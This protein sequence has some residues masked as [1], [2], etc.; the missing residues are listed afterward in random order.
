MVSFMLP[1]YGR[2]LSEQR[3]VVKKIWRV[4][5]PPSP[6]DDGIQATNLMKR[7]DGTVA[8]YYARK[9]PLP[10]VKDRPNPHTIASMDRWT[11]H[12]PGQHPFWADYMLSG[13]SLADFPGVT[14]AHKQ[15]PEAT[16]EILVAA[17]DPD[18]P[19][20]NLDQGGVQILEPLTHV[21]Q[22]TTTDER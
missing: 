13:S 2:I 15:F 20:E 7:I 1:L 11:L 21:V 3:S 5:F 8:G 4:A 19:K 14:P 10:P 9:W 17:I 18:F 16:H 22:V 12:L 6:E